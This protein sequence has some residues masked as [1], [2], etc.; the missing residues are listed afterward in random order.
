MLVA[1]LNKAEDEDLYEEY[2]FVE[3]RKYGMLGD[4]LCVMLWL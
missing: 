2:I 3:R 4:L 1:Q